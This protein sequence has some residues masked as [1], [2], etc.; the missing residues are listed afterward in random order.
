MDY[1]V[2]VV[3]CIHSLELLRAIVLYY[4]TRNI[5]IK[6]RG[7]L[8]FNVFFHCIF[9]KMKMEHHIHENLIFFIQI[10][11]FINI[12]KLVLVKFYSGMNN[13]KRHCENILVNFRS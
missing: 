13:K 4:N 7:L 11:L 9:G 6:T 12:H 5:T 1:N 3:D 2:V 8:L 10:Y